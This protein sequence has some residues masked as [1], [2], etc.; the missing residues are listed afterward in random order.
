M[1]DV[2]VRWVVAEVN[3]IVFI[4]SEHQSTF[5]QLWQCVDVELAIEKTPPVLRSIRCG[6]DPFRIN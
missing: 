4:Y 6:N 5:L 3:G 1:N 2:K